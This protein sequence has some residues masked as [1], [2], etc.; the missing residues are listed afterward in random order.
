MLKE[1]DLR[2]IAQWHESEDIGN[3]ATAVLRGRYNGSYFF[4]ND[5]DGLLVTESECCLNI[6]KEEQK[7]D[8]D[9]VR[10]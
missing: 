8:N 9:E 2:N 5:C 10:G 6:I 4:C 7:N 3:R 1:Q